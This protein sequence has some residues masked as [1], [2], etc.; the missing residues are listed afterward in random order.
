VEDLD[1]LGMG[2]DEVEDLVVG[3]GRVLEERRERGD[4]LPAAGR[5]VDEEDPAPFGDLRYLS[6]DAV[7]PRPDSVGEQVGRLGGGSGTRRKP[8]STIPSPRSGF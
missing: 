4:G 2:A 5:G 3:R 7:L 8:G 6:E 1:L